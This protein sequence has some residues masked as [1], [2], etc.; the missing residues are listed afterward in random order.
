MPTVEYLD[1]N[2][3]EERGWDLYGEDLFEK[4]RAADLD[5]EEYGRF[6]TYDNEYLLVAAERQGF[7]WPFSCRS[8][9]CA[10]C[11]CV[12]SEGEVSMTNQIVL[13][14]EEIDER[15][16]RLTCTSRAETEEI[17]IVFNAKELEHL[18]D[19]VI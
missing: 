6:D 7:T 15:D 3:V 9:S 8:G 16:I 18:Q 14:K 17:K 1:Y 10:N 13:E 2:V 11:A 19:R 5:E 4:A 12:L